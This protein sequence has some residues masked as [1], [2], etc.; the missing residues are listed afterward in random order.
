MC[1]SYDEG[2]DIQSNVYR[3]LFLYRYNDLLFANLLEKIMKG[4]ENMGKAV[5]KRKQKIQYRG[6]CLPINVIDES[7]TVR[8]FKKETWV[9]L[10]NGLFAL[11]NNEGKCTGT[12]K[13][14]HELYSE[15]QT[16]ALK[17]KIFARRDFTGQ[18][19]QYLVSPYVIGVR[20]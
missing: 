11:M 5:S 3:P 4:V 10:W 12:T 8:T 18:P 20:K 7:S 17:D 13:S 19:L 15:I 6:I 14:L 9:N 16:V 1:D 2:D